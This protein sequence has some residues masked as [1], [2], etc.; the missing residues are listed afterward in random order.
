MEETRNGTGLPRTYIASRINISSAKMKKS[1]G[2]GMASMR[3]T[4]GLGMVPTTSS[5]MMMTQ[6]ARMCQWVK[7]NYSDRVRGRWL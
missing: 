5:A 6:E 4:G 7:S 2:M 1:E 3:I